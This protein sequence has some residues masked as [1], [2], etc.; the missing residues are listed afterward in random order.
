MSSGEKQLLFNLSYVL[1]HLKNLSTKRNLISRITINAT[2]EYKNAL[3]I[4]DEAELYMHP[5]YQRQYIYKLISS[6]QKC[7]FENIKDIHIIFATHSPYLLSDVKSNNVLMLEDGKIREN[8]FTA[9]TFAA[10]IYDLLK[11]QFFMTSPVGEFARIKM[12]EIL[13]SFAN[14]EPI[15]DESLQ[16]FI[17]TIGDSY[18]R[19]TLNSLRSEY[20]QEIRKER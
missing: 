19:K 18:I 1:Y 13:K 3:L 16:Q 14:K 11:T 6:I 10:N 2:P 15:D 8:Q 20:F 9:Q 4:F 7:H 17:D 12:Q 5:D